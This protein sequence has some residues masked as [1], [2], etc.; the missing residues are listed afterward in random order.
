[1]K[2][3]IPNKVV[4]AL[5]RENTVSNNRTAGLWLQ[6]MHLIDTVYKII[7]SERLGD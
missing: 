7:C 6:Y 4:N 2:Y 5:S 3:D 1:M